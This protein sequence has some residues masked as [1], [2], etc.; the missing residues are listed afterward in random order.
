MKQYLLFLVISLNACGSVPL[1]ADS[2]II[3]P[4][5][6]MPIVKD[7]INI[8]GDK[9]LPIGTIVI[10]KI[11]DEY[12]GVC[13]E[14]TAVSPWLIQL[15]ETYY[16]ELSDIQKRSLVYHELT[17]CM[18]DSETHSPD[19]TNYMYFEL[20]FDDSEFI[21]TKQVMEYVFHL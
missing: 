2:N 8:V 11:E 19:I 10:K 9:K 3:A 7:F 12:E 1:R 18:F 17:H 15:N 20:R 16:R 14:R 5:E 21:L 4:D 6:V 13:Y